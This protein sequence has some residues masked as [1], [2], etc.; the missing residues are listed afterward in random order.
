LAALCAQLADDTANLD[1]T[2]EQSAAIQHAVARAKS[3]ID[4]FLR[5]SRDQKE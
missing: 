1:R 3:A 5:V 2:I 4:E